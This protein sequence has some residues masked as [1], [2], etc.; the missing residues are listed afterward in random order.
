MARGV[1]GGESALVVCFDNTPEDV[2]KTWFL[3]YDGE[4]DSATLVAEEQDSGSYRGFWSFD[5]AVAEAARGY[6][7]GEF[8]A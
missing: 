7:E 8:G 3:V 4:D 5:T 1:R 6:I 2:A